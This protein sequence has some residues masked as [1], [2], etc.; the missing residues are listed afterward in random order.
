MSEKIKVL[1]MAPLSTGGISKLTVDVNKNIDIEK[2]RFDYLVFRNRAE[3]LE[4]EIKE[5]GSKKQ[6]VDVENV[7]NPIF[8]FIKKCI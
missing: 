6:I 7:K 3:F 4:E 1:H 2:I 5:L 8:R